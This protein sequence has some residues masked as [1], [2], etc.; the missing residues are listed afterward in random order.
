[1]CKESGQQIDL[2]RGR[3]EMAGDG[4]GCPK[5]TGDGL[6]WLGMAENGW[7]GRKSPGIA[8]KGWERPGWTEMVPIGFPNLI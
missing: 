4:R 5:M 6:K 8:R 2:G 7:D 3:L 1:M